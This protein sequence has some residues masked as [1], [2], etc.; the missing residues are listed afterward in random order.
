MRPRR[1]EAR[2]R[3]RDPGQNQKARVVSNEADV[4]PPRFGT[5]S[6][7]SVPAAQVARRRTPRQARDR[8][9]LRPHQILQVFAHRLLVT[10]IVMVLDQAI[11]QRLL[12]PCAGLVRVR[13]ARVGTASR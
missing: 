13:L 12:R 3:N 6:Y 5:P 1:C 10:Q 7:I 2:V 4:T 8:A 11:E 9:A